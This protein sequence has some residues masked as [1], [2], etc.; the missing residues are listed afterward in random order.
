MT[1]E[2]AG[3]IRGSAGGEW[4]GRNWPSRIRRA[5]SEYGVVLH[6]G[7]TNDAIFLCA[8]STSRHSEPPRCAQLSEDTRATASFY[9]AIAARY[10]AEVDGSA[11]NTNVRSAFQR[12]ATAITGAGRPILDFG[13]GTGA[14]AAWYAARGHRVIAYDISAEM[15]AGLRERCA[16]E[17]AS[18]AISA[19]A[20]D[21]DSLVDAL[22]RTGRVATI[23][24]NFAVLNHVR[25]LGLLLDALAPHLADGGAVVMSL[26][27]PFYRRDIVQCWWWRG[28]AGSLQT[29]AIRSDGDV[30]TYRHF[31]RTVCRMASRRFILTEWRGSSSESVARP[32][33]SARA[34]LSDNFVFAVLRRR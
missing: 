1:I 20:G 19:I 2:I 4:H 27:N 11:E 7:R 22:S 24:A 15:V 18:G 30:T 29:G 34:M 21:L 5:R 9:D 8:Y 13:C 16:S 14:D 28:M 32:I 10:D 31:R 6:S 33:E 17:I 12:R 26:L 3:V 25:D 23:T